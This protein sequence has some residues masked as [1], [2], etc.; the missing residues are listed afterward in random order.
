MLEQIFKNCLYV[1]K[2]ND[3]YIPVRFTEK[4]M[5]AYE[6]EEA[7]Y[8]RA[9]SCAGVSMEFITDQDEVSFE[10]EGG[11]YSRP[12]L[13]LDIY[14]N[15]VLIQTITDCE[16]LKHGK[17]NYKRRNQ[18]KKS[19]ITIYLPYSARLRIFNIDIGNYETI[20]DE[21][22]LR[23]L[24]IGDSITQGIESTRASLTYPTLIAR[25]FDAVLLN[26]AVGGYKY[27]SESLD[28]DLPY[29]PDFVTIAY[30]TNDFKHLSDE[31]L[32]KRNITDYYKKL[33]GMFSCP[34]NV[35][36]PIWRKEIDYD[37]AKRLKFFRIIDIIND[38]ASKYD[39]HVIDGLKL[40]PHNEEYYYD[41]YLH[42]NAKGFLCYALNLIKQIKIK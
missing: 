37:E 3:G 33:E 28:E 16:H 10:Y 38:M 32:I 14:E 31:S 24:A 39:Y 29:K 34:I 15:D 7:Y 12:R 21:G 42:P 36:T 25:H 6:K 2:S 9:N 27:L 23:Y 17:V 30:G 5:K 13:I 1:E 18:G 4:Q 22:K 8:I 26:Q 40:I 19:K 41:S 35:I 11:Y 20:S